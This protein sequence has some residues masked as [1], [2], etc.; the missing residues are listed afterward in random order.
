MSLSVKATYNEGTDWEFSVSD[1]LSNLISGGLFNENTL[2]EYCYTGFID[3]MVGGVVRWEAIGS[4]DSNQYA[5]EHCGVYW[6]NDNKTPNHVIINDVLANKGDIVYMRN[7]LLY[8]SFLAG[9]EMNKSTARVVV[10]IHD[11][12]K[13]YMD[14]DKGNGIYSASVES[15]PTYSPANAIS[16]TVYRYQSTVNYGATIVADK[17][18]GTTLEAQSLHPCNILIIN[19][20]VFIG[21]LNPSNNYVPAPDSLGFTGYS[22]SWCQNN[23][24][25]YST[26]YTWLKSDSFMYTES[27][28]RY[29]GY[30]RVSASYEFPDVSTT[31][32][33]KITYIE[34][35]NGVIARI[36]FRVSSDYYYG[37]NADYD[38]AYAAKDKRTIK[39]WFSW[40]GLKFKSEN[41][42]YKPIIE[43][44]IITGYT[45]DMDLPSEFDNMTNV[46]GNNIPV[47]PPSPGPAP[48]PYDDDPWSG[49]S[50]SG[51]GV[52]GA[53]AFAKCYYMTSTELANLRSW[54]NSNNVPEG[55]DPMQ[56]IIGLS[57]VPVTLS[58]DDNTTVQFVNSSAVYDPGVTRLVDSGVNTQISMGTPKRYSLGSVDITRRMQERG[59]PY[60]D[61]D[62]QIE[63]YLPL[64]GMFSLDTQAVMGRTITAEAVLDP[65]S[66]TLA[67]YAYVT[68]DGQNLPIA[69][70]STTIGVD[71]P[72]SAQ[73]LSVS[74]AALKQ[75]N[76]QLGTSLLSSALTMLAAA[77]SGKSSG[78]GAKTST[79]S[80][81][82][83]AAGIREAGSDYMKASQVGNVF[84]D[85]MNWGRTIRQL[86]YGNN[87]AIAGSF[88][89]STAQWAYPFTPYVKI[90]RPR[91]E[92]PSNYNHSQ[93]VPCIQTKT[94]GS[95]TGF[96]QCIGVD[97]SGISGATDL[98]LQ[99]IQAALSN[100]IYAGGGQS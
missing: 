57:Q 1:T 15:A 92:K 16:G 95:C 6:N 100:G 79:G 40:C 89:G 98:E 94:V 26:L 97:V 9:N 88:G 25:G 63:L 35:D 17:P 20:D 19:D 47:T 74:R 75:A 5:R 22:R 77:S 73:Q 32:G 66:G 18:E 33:G 64:I 85:F 53:G 86:S 78:S 58:G 65:I 71:L 49:A 30:P 99:A 3:D 56:Q 61:Y 72:I 81:G 59:E 52:G 29:I 31:D 76:A 50:F 84:G 51:V 27:S 93:G 37:T 36:G 67:A 41:V 12:K 91:Y 34:C 42:M 48:G 55:F 45:S 68:R 2:A 21:F 62:C 43:G 82:L 87:T 83:S 38:G 44:G 96:I 60:L 23:S 28:N 24:Y 10:D 11:I 7:V 80:S 8:N 90:I 70:G 46:T 4:G 14:F 54:M 13:W 39:K 69:Y